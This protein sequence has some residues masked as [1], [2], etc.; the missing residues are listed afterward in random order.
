MANISHICSLCYKAQRPSR[1]TENKCAMV[2]NKVL[3]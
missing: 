1:N 3:Q 2:E